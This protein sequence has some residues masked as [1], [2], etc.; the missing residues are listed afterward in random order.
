MK[1]KNKSGIY[2]Q[3]DVL[4]TRI[5]AIPA[6]AQKPVIRGGKP[7][8]IILALGEATGHHHSLEADAADWWKESDGGD[9]FLD[10]RQT[11][12]VTHQEHAPITLKPGKYRVQIQREY[13]PEKIR[14]VAD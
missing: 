13:S 4:I 1:T 10:V 11:A 14:N 5:E 8:R 3:G 6:S 7:E 2:R 9:Q 12:E